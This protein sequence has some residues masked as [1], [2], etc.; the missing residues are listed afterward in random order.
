M[1]TLQVSILDSP[2]L[3]KK[4]AR[5]ELSDDK[6]YEG[7]IEAGRI[8]GRGTLAVRSQAYLYSGDFLDNCKHGHG[9]EVWGDGRKFEGEFE[10]DLKAGFGE[11]TMADGSVYSGMF[12]ADQF[13]GFGVL[14]R[15]GKFVYQGN[16]NKGSQHGPGKLVFDSG[17]VYQGDFFRGQMHGKGLYLSARSGASYDGEW[18]NGKQHGV[19]IVSEP[20]LPKAKA[21]FQDGIQV[22]ILDSDHN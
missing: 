4:V 12:A 19:G 3:G 21:V 20:G 7:E 13:E 5:L 6:V 14:T 9:S 17:D 15:P 2:G 16:F 8:Q 22:S 11:M 1:G 18:A 10:H